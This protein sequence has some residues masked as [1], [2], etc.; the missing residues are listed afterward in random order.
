MTPHDPFRG[1]PRPAMK[2]AGLSRAEL[3]DIASGLGLPTTGTKA[4]LAAR[5]RDTTGDH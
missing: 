2:L 1:H 5:I 4:D 3:Q